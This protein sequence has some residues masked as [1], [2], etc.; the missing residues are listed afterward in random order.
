VD[1]P[2]DLDESRWEAV[3]SAYAMWKGLRGDWPIDLHRLTRRGGKGWIMTIDEGGSTERTFYEPAMSFETLI[4]PAGPVSFF[5]P[6][7]AR[8]GEVLPAQMNL[9]E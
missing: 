8:C 2:A 6:P 7:D 3:M 1:L 4:F 5:W 9:E